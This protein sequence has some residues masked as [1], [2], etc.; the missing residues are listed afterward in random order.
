M[1]LQ[2]TINLLT[3]AR[4]VANP[5]DLNALIQQYCDDKDDIVMSAHNTE[6]VHVDAG[7]GGDVTVRYTC[8]NQNSLT[9]NVKVRFAAN[10]DIMAVDVINK[11]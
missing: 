9:F 3:H 11:N 6:L 4:S 7:W 10:F 1:D 2:V 8:L 5:E